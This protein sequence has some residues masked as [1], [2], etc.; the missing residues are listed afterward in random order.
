MRSLEIVQTVDRKAQA[1]ARG[2]GQWGNNIIT[3]MKTA[4]GPPL[5]AEETEFLDQYVVWRRSNPIS[6]TPLKA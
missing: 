3:E 1:I 4:F 5:T 2:N 6:L